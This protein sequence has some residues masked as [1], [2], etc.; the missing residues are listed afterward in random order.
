MNESQ[1]EFKDK[2]CKLFIVKNILDLINID[3]IFIYIN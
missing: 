3:W 1:F 2:V